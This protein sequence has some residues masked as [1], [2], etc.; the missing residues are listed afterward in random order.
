MGSSQNCC[1]ICKRDQVQ[2][3]FPP[4]ELDVPVGE[5]DCLISTNTPSPLQLPV[6]PP[7][8]FPNWV[9]NG[10]PILKTRFWGPKWSATRGAI[11]GIHFSSFCPHKHSAHRIPLCETLGPAHNMW[12]RRVWKYTACSGI[13][14]CNTPSTIPCCCC[15]CSICGSAS[16]V[17][18][19]RKVR[20]TMP[21]S[22]G[23]QCRV[24]GQQGNMVVSQDYCDYLIATCI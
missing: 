20:E 23:L 5:R 2:E 7:R 13:F 11:G 6:P 3:R 8:G 9:P 17:K 10:S 16:I 19:W 1:S 21:G 22:C 12:M 4:H 15:W 24:R 18:F 14:I